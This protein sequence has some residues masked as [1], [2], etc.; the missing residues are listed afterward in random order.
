MDHCSP[1]HWCLSLADP[2]PVLIFIPVQSSSQQ[3]DSD[4]DYYSQ[5]ATEKLWQINDFWVFV[6]KHHMHS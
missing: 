1:F 2:A 5:V 4:A 3:R 6:K